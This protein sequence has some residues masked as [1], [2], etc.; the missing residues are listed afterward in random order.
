MESERGRLAGRWGQLDEGVK[1]RW[2]S[3]RARG[4]FRWGAVAAALAG[5]AVLLLAVVGGSGGSSDS[6]APG[7]RG[8]RVVTAS[9]LRAEA[10]RLGQ[11]IY[12]AGPW[13]GKEL[14]LSEESGGGV[15]VSYVPDGSPAEG[16]G[17]GSVT[18][19]SYPVADAGAAMRRLAGEPGSRS[20]RAPD[21]RMVVVGEGA[22]N[23]AYFV[24]PD[25]SVEVEVYDQSARRAWHWATSGKVQPAG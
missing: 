21:G 6:L 18:V 2:R 25:G 7:R 22:P 4:R 11:P 24:S 1:V 12:W 9:G 13:R 19:G 20:W 5:L 23:S 14:V 16:S 8:P 3:L 10:A 15:Q 17:Q